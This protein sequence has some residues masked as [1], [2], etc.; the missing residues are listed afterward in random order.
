MYLTKHVKA[1]FGSCVT[2]LC[3][4]RLNRQICATYFCK[5]LQHLL[6]EILIKPYPSLKLQNFAYI[7]SVLLFL[8]VSFIIL[9]QL[10]K[11]FRVNKHSFSFGYFSNSF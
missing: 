5:S 2:K 10:S 4:I 8:Q 7:N 3:K 11:K 1:N 6:S 9:K